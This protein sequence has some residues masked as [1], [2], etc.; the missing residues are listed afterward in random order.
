MSDDSD[1]FWDIVGSQSKPGDFL[2]SMLSNC[3]RTTFVREDDVFAVQGDICPNLE[4]VRG[5]GIVEMFC[6]E[7][8]ITCEIYIIDETPP[9]AEEKTT[10]DMDDFLS[11]VGTRV[12]DD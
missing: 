12:E 1:N 3:G 4:T 7:C 8:G 11:I 10:S 6:V 9:A 2:E 5:E